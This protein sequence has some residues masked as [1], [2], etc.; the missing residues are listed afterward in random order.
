VESLD[1]IQ[2]VSSGFIQAM[3]SAMMDLLTLESGK[4]LIP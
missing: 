3:V 2:Q 4:L 1:V